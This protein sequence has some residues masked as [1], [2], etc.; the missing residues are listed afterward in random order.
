MKLLFIGNYQNRTAHSE[1]LAIKKFSNN[2]WV[3]LLC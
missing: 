2:S 3:E 1:E